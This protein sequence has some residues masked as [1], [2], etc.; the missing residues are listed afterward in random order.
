LKKRTRKN[1]RRQRGGGEIENAA[2][3][4][5]KMNGILNLN[6]SLIGD[7][8]VSYIVMNS[9]FQDLAPD[10]TEL[11][12]TKTE[13]SSIG[14]G[15]IK[16][17]LGKGLNLKKLKK[18][19]LENN[20]LGKEGMIILDRISGMENLPN[21]E[22]L[23]IGY[24]NIGDKG[25]LFLAHAISNLPKLTELN[26]EK[27]EIGKAGA[28]ALAG[29][30]PELE[31]LTTL[32]LAHNMLDD[33]SVEKIAKALEGL[34]NFRELIL[35]GNRFGNVGTYDIEEALKGFTQHYGNRHFIKGV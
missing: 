20:R 31:N 4:G 29:I 34:P 13:I 18:L 28:I 33:V 21:L 1:Q 2:I 35:N 22:V 11:D 7:E 3:D 5:A 8:G 6:N 17:G 30:L 14:L 24:N 15:Y 26:L 23:N 25:A 32:N 10:L 16:Y 9:V 12:L 19:I 27:N